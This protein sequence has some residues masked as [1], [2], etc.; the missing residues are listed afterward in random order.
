MRSSKK[1]KGHLTVD[2]TYLLKGC[3]LILLLF[4]HLF[5]TG[6]IPVD[7]IMIGEAPLVQSIGIWCKVCVAIFILLSGY[8]LSMSYRPVGGGNLWSFYKKRYVK[9]M[10]NYWF[11]YLLFVPFGVFVM[12]RTFDEVYHGSWVRPILDLLGLYKAF[13][14][15]SYGYNPTWWFYSCIII[16]YA[17]YPF[18]AKCLKHT[19]LMIVVVLVSILFGSHIPVYNVCSYY[20]P[21]FLLGMYMATFEYLNALYL[22][23][24]KLYIFMMLPFVC[25][26]R[27]WMPY[28]LL[29]DAIIAFFIVISFMLVNVPKELK[30]ILVFIGKHS[31]NIF[32]FHTFIYL[33]YFQS[34]IYWTTN[35]FL[36]FVTMFTT[37]VIISVIIEY[38]KN[39][40]GVKRFQNFLI[41][42]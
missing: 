24:Y 37:C 19:W 34:Y 15:D 27:F 39:T 38:L 2:D 16:L 36:I 31:F 17:I 8:G 35:P 25:M 33:L 29:W 6:D 12:G 42:I 41:K 10:V 21:S 11:I 13:T 9:L 30:Y 22:V 1:L 20:L 32:L 4:H 23:K 18:L 3:A 14:G 5:Y 7:E 40:L 28:A 26:L